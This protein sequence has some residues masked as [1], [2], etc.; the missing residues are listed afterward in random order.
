MKRTTRSGGKI[1]WREKYRIWKRD[2]YTCQYCG[3]SADDMTD[4]R[5]LVVDHIIPVSFIVI[6]DISNLITSCDKCNSKLSD[7]VFSNLNEKKMYIKTRGSGNY[8]KYI[9]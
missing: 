9:K 4:C 8:K 1:L 7:K 3:Y 6:N 5:K 2:N